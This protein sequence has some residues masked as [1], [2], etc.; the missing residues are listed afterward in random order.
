M[1]LESESAPVAEREA[2]SCVGEESGETL[3]EVSG[4]ETLPPP[5]Q[6]ETGKRIQTSD[7][8]TIFHQPVQAN[9]LGDWR[10]PAA[11]VAGAPKSRP[12]FPPCGN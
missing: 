10:S 3:T 5:A 6:R 8:I 7:P 2:T 4:R 1:L 9:W 11:L 12:S